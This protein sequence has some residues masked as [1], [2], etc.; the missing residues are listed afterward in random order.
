MTRLALGARQPSHRETQTILERLRMI[1]AGLA[2]EALS[3][4]HIFI[5][6]SPLVTTYTVGTTLYISS[7][8]VRN[9]EYL[10]VLLAHE[11]G[12]VNN[13]DGS[14]VLALRRLVFPLFYLFFGNISQY[15]TMRA[16]PPSN[17]APR[18]PSDVYYAV[19]NSLLFALMAFL[20]GGVGVYLLSLWWANY[21]RERDYLADQFVVECGLRDTLLEYLEQNRFYD[22]SVPY[23]LGWQP[24][25]ELRIDRLLNPDLVPA[26]LTAEQ[27]RQ[28]VFVQVTFVAFMLSLFSFVFFPLL[29]VRGSVV[30]LLLAWVMSYLLKEGRKGLLALARSLF[31]A[32][33]PVGEGVRMAVN[34]FIMALVVNWVLHGSLITFLIFYLPS[35]ALVFFAQSLLF[36]RKDDQIPP[37]SLTDFPHSQRESAPDEHGDLEEVVEVVDTPQPSTA[38]RR[39]DEGTAETPSPVA[40]AMVQPA[41]RG[42]NL[43]NAGETQLQRRLLDLARAKGEDAISA[44]DVYEA[45]CDFAAVARNLDVS[46]LMAEVKRLIAQEYVT[47]REDVIDILVELNASPDVA[48]SERYLGKLSTL[49][50][51][52]KNV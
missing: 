41:S 12:H 33:T 9:E 15:S 5:L 3:F 21:F 13:G 28:E 24:A 10:E 34:A 43:P 1:R 23:M 45:L 46:I 44:R 4:S 11:L 50:Q 16:A 20:G 18:L 36:G 22:T 49:L 30:V 42:S 52:R 2:S 14:L 35:F 39:F 32:R 38:L 37:G 51:Q 48:T 47:L 40:S 31:K 26:P 27:Q 17:D 7:G 8:A 6:D 25:N 19:I 29:G